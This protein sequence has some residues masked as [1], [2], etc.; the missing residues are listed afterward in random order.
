MKSWQEKLID[1]I[2]KE[3]DIFDTRPKKERD[4]HPD[5]ECYVNDI[6][7]LV[8]DVIKEKRKKL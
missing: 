6:L 3:C 1:L 4:M 7:T 8:E 2:E 5:G